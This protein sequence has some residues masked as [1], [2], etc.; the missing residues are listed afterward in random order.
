M[1]R[2]QWKRYL[3]QVIGFAMIAVTVLLIVIFRDVFEKPVEAKK[4]VQQIKVLQ[5]PPPPPPPPPQPEVKPPEI[6]EE[7]I[8]PVEQE[9]EPEPEPEPAEAPVSDQLGVDA[10]AAADRVDQAVHR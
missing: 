10:G 5:A 3:P 4:Q 1:K 8:E 2:F 7:K 6:K 9:P